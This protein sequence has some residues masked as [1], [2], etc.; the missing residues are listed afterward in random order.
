MLQN[1]TSIIYFNKGAFPR[2]VT[3]MRL[4]SFITLATGLM[5]S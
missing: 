3:L 2:E 1:V 4:E 5:G